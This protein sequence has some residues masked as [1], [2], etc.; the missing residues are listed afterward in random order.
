MYG[1]GGE[2]SPKSEVLTWLTGRVFY[3]AVSLERALQRERDG[4]NE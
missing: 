2:M 3:S 1:T 4:M